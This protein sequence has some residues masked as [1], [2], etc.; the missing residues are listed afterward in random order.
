MKLSEF[1]RRARASRLE[2]KAKHEAAFERAIRDL[3][4]PTIPARPSR[5]MAPIT[6]IRSQTDRPQ[7]HHPVLTL[8]PQNQDHQV[9]RASS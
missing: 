2:K 4:L 7:H 3:N 5:L 6:Y 9:S 1:T 8:F